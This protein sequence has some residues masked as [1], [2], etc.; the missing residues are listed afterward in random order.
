MGELVAEQ[1]SAGSFQAF[2]DV[3][4][5][6][7]RTPDKMINQGL[8]GR[9]HDLAKLDFADGRAGISLFSSQAKSA[10]FRFELV[11]RHPLGSQAFI[12][13]DGVAYL[14][15][16]AEDDNGTPSGLRAFVAQPGQSVNI[17]R[18]VW[19]GVLTPIDTPGNYVVVDRI[20]EGDNLEEHWFDSPVTVAL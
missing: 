15:V 12:P 4:E 11:E 14:V 20:G 10:P 5:A 6:S 18:N 19:H 7:D 3:I 1:L 17:H 13:V 9:F 16:V 8:C 2:G